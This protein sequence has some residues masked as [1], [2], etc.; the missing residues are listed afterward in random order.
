MFLLHLKTLL[1][2][3]VLPPA[4]PL[5]VAWFGLAVLRRR[6]VLARYCLG[7]SI[8]SLTLLS[9]PLVASALTAVVER[10]PALDLAAPSGAEAVVILGGGGQR[11]YAP[12][13]G[14]PAAK[15]GLLE[16][17][18]YGAYVA[19]R[20][21]LPV[22]VTGFHVEARAMRAS[23]QR[24]FYVEPR[25]VDDQSYDTFENARNSAK[26][27]KTAGIHRI[28]LVTSAVHL[29]RASHEF[30]AAGLEVVPAPVGNGDQHAEG[31]RSLVP[32]GEALAASRVALYELLGEGVRQFFS[33]T[34]IRRQ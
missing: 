2:M 25:W 19:H 21:A 33:F 12:E 27:L 34:G 1:R 17:L 29:W 22:L 3:L 24:S 18:E 28:I 7:F 4:G 8:G 32:D 26:L 31:P 11:E 15:P 10:Y 9:L 13:Y 20:T 14:G 30:V 16:R 6:P 5:F 23:L